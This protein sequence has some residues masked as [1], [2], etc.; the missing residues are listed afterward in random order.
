MAKNAFLFAE[1]TEKTAYRD[2]KTQPAA[3]VPQLEPHKCP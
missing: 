3:A 1:T 2:S